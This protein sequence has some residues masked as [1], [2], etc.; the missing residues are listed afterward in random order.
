MKLQSEQVL[1]GD[2]SRLWVDQWYDTLI[3]TMYKLDLVSTL[4][5]AYS[6]P[7]WSRTYVYDRLMGY[8]K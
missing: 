5:W 7:P 2:N 1:H 4:P 8:K 3:L 6:V